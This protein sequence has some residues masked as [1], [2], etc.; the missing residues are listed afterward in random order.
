MVMKRGLLLAFTG[1]S[2]GLLVALAANRLLSSLLFEVRATDPN[3]LAL[4]ILVLLVVAACASLIPA[5]NGTRISPLE[6]MRAE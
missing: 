4:A 1:G 6:A 2:V 5:L 3:A